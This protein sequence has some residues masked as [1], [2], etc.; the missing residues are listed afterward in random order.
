MADGDQTIVLTSNTR[1]KVNQTPNE[2]V[3]EIVATATFDADDTSDVTLAVP[4]NGTLR[5]VVLKVPNTTNAITTQLQIQDNGDNVVFDTGELAENA[6][7][8]FSVDKSLS[9]TIDLV[10]GVS[11]AVGASGSIIVATLRGI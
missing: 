7:Y 1:A 2:D 8:I 11:G 6:T 5:D 4:L 9:G 10:V 3:W